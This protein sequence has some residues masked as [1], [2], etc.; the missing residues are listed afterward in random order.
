[1]TGITELLLLHTLFTSEQHIYL[2]ATRDSFHLISSH[3]I[4]SHFIP[5]QE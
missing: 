2:D 3:L 4:S 5:V 1:M